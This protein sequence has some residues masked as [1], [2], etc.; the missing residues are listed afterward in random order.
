MRKTIFFIIILTGL[1]AATAAAQTKAEEKLFQEAKILLFD[2]KWEEAQAKLEE[3]LVEYPRSPLAPQAI[4][5]RAKCLGKQRGQQ[6]KA[7]RAYEDYLY[8][9]DKNVSMVEEAETSIIDLAYDLYIGRGGRDYLEKIE[10]RLQSPSSNIRYYAA[11]KLSQVKDKHIASRAVPVL[12]QMVEKEADPDYK[13]RAKIALMRISPDSLKGVEE[14]AD[15]R[16]SAKILKIRIEIR[17]QKEPELSLNIP[18]ALA[19]LA[20]SAIPEKDK[21][22]LRLEGYDLDKIVDQLTGMK[23]NIIEIRDRENKDRVIRIWIE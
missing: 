5:Y 3:L 1:L 20:L 6:E 16:R 21:A 23:D 22:A 19:D 9:P 15:T 8:T 18:W 4:F 14:R 10:D 11:L 2:E 7:L 17:G 12:K 13:D